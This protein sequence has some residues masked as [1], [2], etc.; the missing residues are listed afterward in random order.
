MAMPKKIDPDAQYRVTISEPAL[1][2][3]RTL[4]PRLEHV[5]SGKVLE[6]IKDVVIDV[7]KATD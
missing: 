7:A 5:V 4:K 3:R 1:V 2:G 6:Q